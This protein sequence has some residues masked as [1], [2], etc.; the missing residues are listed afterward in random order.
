MAFRV[1]V[2]RDHNEVV[3]S[4]PVVGEKTKVS[5]PQVEQGVVADYT[6][7]MCHFHPPET[8]LI[9]STNDF[10]N[11]HRRTVAQTFSRFKIIDVVGMADSEQSVELLLLQ[12]T[13]QDI[14]PALHRY[15]YPPSESR[16]SYLDH[17]DFLKERHNSLIVYRVFERFRRKVVIQT[18]AR[19]FLGQPDFI[20]DLI[21]E[22]EGVSHGDY[23][24]LAKCLPPTYVTI[25]AEELER[26]GLYRASYKIQKGRW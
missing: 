3:Y 11:Q 17:R 12:Q 24:R 5:Y 20:E 13:R 14:L 19:L 21:F 10:Y 16:A 2:M 7:V 15:L 9:P 25:L 22:S 1:D 18:L 4:K 26:T 6:L 8:V 23:V